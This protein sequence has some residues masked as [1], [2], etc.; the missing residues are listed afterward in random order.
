MSKFLLYRLV[1]TW[2][3][4]LDT[5]SEEIELRIEISEQVDKS[6]TFKARIFRYESYRLQSTFPQNEGAPL[7]APSDEVIL[8]EFESFVPR[9]ANAGPGRDPE[10]VLEET[11]AELKAWVESL[12]V[13]AS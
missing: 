13:P 12:R 4:L 2:E 11:V 1:Q 7:H 9:Y 6:G 3:L 5:G 10:H 8:K